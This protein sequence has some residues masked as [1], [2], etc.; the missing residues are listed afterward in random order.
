ML[1]KSPPPPP[2]PREERSGDGDCLLQELLEGVASS[3]QPFCSMSYCTILSTM[4]LDVVLSAV[5]E[6]RARI[7]GPCHDF[8]LD[9]MTFRKHLR[10]ALA[11]NE[12]RR[13]N[14]I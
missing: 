12:K 1:E 3:S 10:L 6:F 13:Q 2:L 4:C 9:F 5:A 8:P 14:R 11:L 7:H